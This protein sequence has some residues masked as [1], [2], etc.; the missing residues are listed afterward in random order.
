MGERVPQDTLYCAELLFVRLYIAKKCLKML[1]ETSKND[2]LDH[3]RAQWRFRD[4][5]IGIF[6]SW[7]ITEGLLGMH[8]SPKRQINSLENLSE[9][10]WG[11]TEGPRGLAESPWHLA[12]GP[13]V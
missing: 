2:S 13:E 10:F 5:E 6:T 9:G 4:I 12:E 1:S 11:L 8:K 3:L 7:S